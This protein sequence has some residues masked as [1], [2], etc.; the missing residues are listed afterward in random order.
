MIV[1]KGV[2][3]TKGEHKFYLSDL[4]CGHCANSFYRD[5]F[6]GTEDTSRFEIVQVDTLDNILH[7]LGIKKVDFIKMDVEGAEVE[8]L[9]GMNQVLENNDVKLAGEYHVINGKSTYKIIASQLKEKGFEVYKEG[10][11]L[12]ASKEPK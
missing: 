8:A 10:A 9:K 12:Y 2:W 3:S 4:P 1:Q 5:S 6:Y 11:I 7:E